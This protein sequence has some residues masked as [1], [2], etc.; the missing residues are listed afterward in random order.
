MAAPTDWVESLRQRTRREIATEVFVAVDGIMQGVLLLGDEIRLDAS[1]AIRLLRRAGIAR[2]VM[3]T[4]DHRDAADRIGEEL[5]IDEVMAD[6][7][8]ADKLSAIRGAKSAGAV[9]MVGDGI[10][11]APALAAADVG[12]AMGARG[13]AA[14]SEA[15]GMVLLVDRLD[16]LAEAISVARRTRK[17]AMQSALAGIALSLLAMGFAFIGYLA[18]VAGAVLQEGIDVAVILNALRALHMAS[19]IAARPRFEPAEASRLKREH[20]EL[21]PVF[22]RI[23]SCADRLPN[24]SADAARKELA[25]LDDI[26]RNQ[27]LMH[28]RE[29]EMSLYPKLESMLGGDDPLAAMSRAHREIVRLARLFHQMTEDLPRDAIAPAIIQDLQRVLYGLDA[30]LRLHFAQEDEI[31]H[32][33]TDVA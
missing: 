26:L 6:L 11:D 7:T 29:D 13:A 12:V 28:E 22:D 2:V 25:E 19:V 17:I 10:N 1:R 3:L 16:R 21:E 24:L 23:R 31:Y 14:A 27:L 20:H 5:G 33:M 30:I 32:A 8:P 15:A 9:I 4:G 18:P